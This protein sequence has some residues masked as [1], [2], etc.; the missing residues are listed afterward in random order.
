MAVTY[1]LITSRK[2]GDRGDTWDDLE[3]DFETFA[4]TEFDAAQEAYT[5]ASQD[6]GNYIVSLT[7]VVDSTA[8]D[9]HP[10]LRLYSRG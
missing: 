5:E 10:D 1:I 8:Y 6:E 7:A 2:V 3:T 9:T 4:D